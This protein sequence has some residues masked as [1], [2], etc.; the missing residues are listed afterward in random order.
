MKQFQRIGVFLTGLSA[1]DVALGF[2]GQF[3]E[4]AEAEQVLCVY[5]EGGGEET[6]DFEPP[7][8][9]PDLEQYVLGRLPEPIRGRTRVERHPSDGVSE[10]LRSA[11][12]LELDLIVVGRRLPAHQ[13]GV[14]SAFSKL[15]R[16]SPCSVLVAPNFARPHFSRLLVPV[17][18]SDHSRLALETA[19]SLARASGDPHAQVTAQTVFTVGYGYHKTGLTLP[20]AVRKLEDVARQKLAEFVADV[21]TSGVE[22]NTVCTCSDRTAQAIHDLAAAS[23]M[24]M[25]VVG[26]RGL[27]RAAAAIL[28]EVAERILHDAAQPVLIVKRKGETIGLLNALLGT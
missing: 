27:T 8:E 17:D 5:V 4:L 24:D 13:M 22:F 3:A 25:I 1:D 9:A 6:P 12:D 16:K 19:L 28:G 23:K 10:I 18:F 14:G 21:D 26:S 2:A 7:R 11:R 15:A 20:E